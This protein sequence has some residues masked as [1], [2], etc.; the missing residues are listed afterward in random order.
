MRHQEIYRVKEGHFQKQL[1]LG[2]WKKSVFY[3]HLFKGMTVD[4]ISFF[5]AINDAQNALWK[6][7]RLFM[8][9]LL[10]ICAVQAVPT[11]FL[12]SGGGGDTLF[13]PRAVLLFVS[14]R[15]GPMTMASA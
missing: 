2:G 11:P 13:A 12:A 5:V 6:L 3:W 14:E 8:K 15:K 9:K 10:L 7:S 4:N 1:H